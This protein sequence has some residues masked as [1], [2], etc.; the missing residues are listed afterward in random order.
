V[1]DLDYDEQSGY[2]YAVGDLGLAIWDGKSWLHRTQKHLG[3]APDLPLT[4]VLADEGTM[5]WVGAEE[6]TDYDWA[7]D[8]I[9]TSDGGLAYGNWISGP[10]SHFDVLNAPSS[11][12]INDLLL[13]DHGNLWVACGLDSSTGSGGVSMLGTDRNWTHYYSTRYEKPGDL[14]GYWYHSLALGHDGTIYAGGDHLS[15][16]FPNTAEWISRNI[17]GYLY[18]IAIDLQGN[19]WYPYC[20]DNECFALYGT[21][22][23]SWKTE[24]NFPYWSAITFDAEGDFWLA[25]TNGLFEK[26]D[27]AIQPRVVADSLPNN[28]VEQVA[29]NGD[30]SVWFT[31]TRSDA[32]REDKRYISCLAERKITNFWS[33]RQAVEAAYPWT[34]SDSLWSVGPDGMIWLKESVTNDYGSITGYQVSGYDGKTWHTLPKIFNYGQVSQPMVSDNGTIAVISDAGLSLYILGEG[35]QE[36]TWPWDGDAYFGSLLFD[37]E[38]DIWITQSYGFFMASEKILRYSPDT[39]EWDT[40]S[41]IDTG[42]GYVPPNGINLSPTGELWVV[43]LFGDGR[44]GVYQGDGT[45]KTTDLGYF[46]SWAEVYFEIDGSPWFTTVVNCGFE[47]YCIDGLLYIDGSRTVHQTVENSGLI[48]GRVNDLSFDS[49]GNVWLATGAGLQ[50][51]PKP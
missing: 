3:F 44:V 19:L 50:M 6:R 1:Y 7:L 17:S 38:G 21:G 18:Q 16:L 27:D 12:Q 37:R 5:I 20:G 36:P 45:W 51:M 8:E 33:E 47:S 10:W 46:H 40:F 29:V 23:N 26:V 4:A 34:G 11:N 31:T 2:L 39:K 43:G 41:S 35:W 48:N 32:Y 28:W 15:Y 22:D 49:N 9:I 24:E 14:E 13:D 25:N 30:D 42:I